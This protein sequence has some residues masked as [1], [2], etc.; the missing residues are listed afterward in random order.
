M[1]SLAV[2]YRPKVF[3]DVCGQGATITILKRQLELR[4]FKNAY[5]FVGPSGVGK[6][7][8][9]RIFA[10]GINN[11][12]GQPIEIDAASNNGV[13]NVKTIVANAQ[14]RSLDSEYKIYII[15]EAHMITTAGWNAF[16]KCIEEPPQYTIFI[17]CTTEVQKVPETIT[18]R[19]QRFN[20]TK[21]SLAEIGHRLEDIL[22][23]EIGVDVGYYDFNEALEYI[24]KISNGSMRQAISYMEKCWDYSKEFTLDDVFE[25]L[26]NYP[27]KLFFD[28]TNMIIDKDSESIIRLVDSVYNKGQDLRLFIDSYL[29]FVLDL[30]KYCLFKDL[31]ATQIPRSYIDEVNYVTDNG[32]QV[33][34]FV[35]LQDKILNIKNLIKYDTSVYTTI[36][37]SLLNIVA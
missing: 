3:E 32:N 4:E 7:T 27:L 5:L 30:S 31:A 23:T 16:L 36:L 33:G 18:N 15:D 21:L 1:E 37:V 29:T 25:V 35:S 2:K 6:T 11:G 24:A 17:F 22:S 20:L 14:E 10:N 12:A 8:L 28:L 26:G 34:Y 9:A 19:V 13:D